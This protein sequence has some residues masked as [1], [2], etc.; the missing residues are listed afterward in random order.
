MSNDSK[1][2]GDIVISQRLTL[3]PR[4]DGLTDE[5]VAFD[6]NGECEFHLEQLDDRKG[7]NQFWMRWYSTKARP[8]PRELILNIGPNGAIQSFDPPQNHTDEQ[9][10][11][12]EFKTPPEKIGQE[13]DHFIRYFGMKRLLEEM[14][15]STV[16]S[17]QDEKTNWPD[18]DIGYL[19]GLINHLTTALK[20]YEDRYP[21]DPD[22]SE[23][24]PPSLSE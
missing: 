4:E 14:I 22:F 10:V 1:N 3:R 13:V 24:E 20:E 18:R 2:I 19:D 12:E 7:Q 6:E 8:L 11:A 9:F 5:V 15:A 16:K 23:G 21:G 17:K